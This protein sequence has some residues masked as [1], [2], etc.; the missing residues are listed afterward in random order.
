MG[1]FVLLP[2]F[3]GSA[4]C[5]ECVFRCVIVMCVALVPASRVQRVVFV[6]VDFAFSRRG[7]VR[8]WMH[9]GC[10]VVFARYCLRSQSRV[11]HSSV[12]LGRD[13]VVARASVLCSWFSPLYSVCCGP[14]IGTEAPCGLLHRFVVSYCLLSCLSHASH[15]ECGV[16]S[17][18]GNLATA[19]L[20]CCCLPCYRP[21]G[22]SLFSA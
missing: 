19:M 9:S 17:V 3:F 5:I 20:R 8:P 22:F 10:A 15:H 1:V 18:P 2:I 14:I 4:V 13:A 6:A 11:R 12:P 21:L 16:Q 7:T